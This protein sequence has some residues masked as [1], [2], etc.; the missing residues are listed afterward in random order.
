M[1]YISLNDY[2]II[3]MIREKD[4]VAYNVMY[5]KYRPLISKLA[6]EYCRA[7]KNCGIEYDELYQEGL[8]ALGNSIREFKEDKNCLF[9]TYALVCIKRE[10]EKIIKNKNRF[11]NKILTDALSLEHCVSST[12]LNLEDIIPDPNVD[13]HD[14]LICNMTYKS[15]LDL[16][17]ELNIN[18]SLIYELKLNNFSNSEIS[19]LLDVSYKVI[20]NSLKTI[21]RKLKKYVKQNRKTML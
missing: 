10:M 14:N 17:Y 6:K 3:Y 15:I 7:Y 4:E 2:E 13:L 5:D 16:K 9:Y 11:K 20:D 19:T 21:K 1:E 18:Q 12:E 8:F